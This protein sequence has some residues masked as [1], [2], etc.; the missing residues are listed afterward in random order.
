M[1]RWRAA[2]IHLAISAFIAA[3]VFA[4]IRLLWYPGALFEGAGGRELFVLIAVVDVTLGPLMTLIVFKAGKPGL[5]FDLA[6][7]AILQVAALGYGA[8]VLFESRPVWIV[9]VKDRFELTRANQVLEAERSKARAPFD[10]LSITGP[11]LAGAEMPADP[12][13][14]L[15]IAISALGG[16][17]INGFPQYLVP[18]ERVRGQVKAK[19]KPLAELRQFNPGQEARIQALETFQGRKAAEVGFLPMRAG[20]HDL[21]ALVDRGSGEFLGTVR[22][23]PW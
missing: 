1:T 13:E 15:R 5:R 10:T 8:M 21:V 22:L 9:F 7:I 23:E 17:D 4:V 11:S 3:A 12:N 14:Q 2:G 6:T 16:L 18:Y 20:R 19:A